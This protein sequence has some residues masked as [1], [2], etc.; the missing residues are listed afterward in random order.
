MLRVCSRYSNQYPY[1]RRT[2]CMNM[3]R[4]YYLAVRAFGLRPYCSAQ[5]HCCPKL[6]WCK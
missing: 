5:S 1:N 3:A 4:T 6:P 2:G